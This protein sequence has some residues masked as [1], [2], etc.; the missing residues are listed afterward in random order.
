[1]APSK[2]SKTWF[3]LVDSKFRAIGDC[4]VVEASSHELVAILKDEVKKK[5]QIDLV[6]VDAD[7][8]IIWKTKG[9]KIIDETTFERTEEILRSIDVDDN[10]TIEKVRS[11]AKVANLGLSKTQVLLVQQPGTSSICTLAA[12]LNWP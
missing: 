8:L 1:M 5:K 11:M 6:H 10:D 2:T 12:F 7:H 9:T 4:F 3:L